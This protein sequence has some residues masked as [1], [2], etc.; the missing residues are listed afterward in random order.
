MAVIL[1]E[2]YNHSGWFINA[3]DSLKKI[4]VMTQEQYDRIITEAIIG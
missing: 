1:M 4:T 2:A 3:E